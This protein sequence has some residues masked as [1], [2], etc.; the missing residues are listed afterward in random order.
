MISEKYFSVPT[1]G[2]GI[3]EINL[4]SLIL[5]F[6][7]VATSHSSSKSTPA[8]GTGAKTGKIFNAPSTMDEKFLKGRGLTQLE[9]SLEGNSFSL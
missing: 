2:V 5:T 7:Q 1:G 8:I 3:R 9:I 6:E 4:P